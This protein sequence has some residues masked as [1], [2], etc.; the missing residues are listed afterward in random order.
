MNY[1]FLAMTVQCY[2]GPNLQS[3]YLEPPYQNYPWHEVTIQNS[4][5][6]FCFTV[7]PYIYL[8]PA[9]SCL[10]S[11]FHMYVWTW[12]EAALRRKATCLHTSIVQ[13]SITLSRTH[14]P[15][16][17]KSKSELTGSTHNG[18][19]YISLLLCTFIPTVL[20]SDHY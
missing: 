17:R 11:P 5:S 4:Q 19:I 16:G 10:L 12:T 8:T 3:L 6:N 2:F 18:L 1:P 7:L 13:P 15:T 14:H 9:G 20:D